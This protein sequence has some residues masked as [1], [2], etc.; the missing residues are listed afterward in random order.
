LLPL[1]IVS[2]ARFFG[3][4]YFSCIASKCGIFIIMVL[5]APL[6]PLFATFILHKNVAG[7]VPYFISAIF[8]LLNQ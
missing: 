6:I 4:K 8:G 7:S 1:A 5:N 2:F 3:E